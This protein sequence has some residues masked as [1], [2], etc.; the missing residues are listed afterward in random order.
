MKVLFVLGFPNPFPSAAWARVGFFA[1]SCSKKHHSVE[2]L[3]TFSLQTLNKRGVKNVDGCNVFNLSFNLGFY[4]PVC[5]IFN[6]LFSFLTTFHFL[7]ARR[8]KITVISVPTGDTGLGAIMACTLLKASFIIDYR[9]EWEDYAISQITSNMG[10]PFYYIIKKFASHLY[11]KSKKLVTVTPNMILSLKK[12]GLT[13]IILLPNGADT[14]IFKIF[15]RVDSRYALSLN[16]NDFIIIHSGG[17]GGYYRV[18]I[19][20]KAIA[21]MGDYLR[22]KVKLLL[23]GSGS[24]VTKIMHISKLLGLEHNVMYLGIKNDKTELAKLFST[25]DVGLIPYD[26]NLLWKNFSSGKI[27]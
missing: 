1:K 22:H 15:D 23:V 10:K 18:D 27:F 7:L 16:K 8:P 26:D 5:F 6:F 14:S 11:A 3:G 4:N 25:A 21:K 19:A 9:D 13:N 24:D 20:I 12:R 2:I 17:I